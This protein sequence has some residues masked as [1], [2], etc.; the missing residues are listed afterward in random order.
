MGRI[1]GIED[2]ENEQN[3]LLSTEGYPTP[4][5]KSMISRG[6]IPNDPQ[7]LQQSYADAFSEDTEGYE[8]TPTMRFRQRVNEPEQFDP[9]EMPKN[10]PVSPAAGNAKRF[11]NVSEQND[12]YAP[13]YAAL[14]SKLVGGSNVPQSESQLQ[15]NDILNVYLARLLEKRERSKE[16]EG[17]QDQ[18]TDDSRLAALA[19]GLSESASKIGN[20]MGKPTGS[21]MTGFGKQ[22][23]GIEQSRVDSMRQIANLENPEAEAAQL[24]TINTALE[25]MRAS[26]SRTAQAQQD[27]DLALRKQQFDEKHKSAELAAQQAKYAEEKRVKEAQKRIPGYTASKDVVADAKEVRDARDAVAER[28]SFNS[29]AD[30]YM[31]AM[32]KVQGFEI[33]GSDAGNIDALAFQLKSSAGELARLGVLQPTDLKRLDELL[34]K[35]V[36]LKGGVYQAGE[37]IG[38]IFNSDKIKK[39]A[40][41]E[42]LL[43][44]MRQLKLDWNIKTEAKLRSLGYTKNSSDKQSEVAGAPGAGKIAIK[45][46]SG[47]QRVKLF[48]RSQADKLLSQKD[49][50]GQPLYIE[51]KP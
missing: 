18:A 2:Y 26:Q 38:K 23:G 49:A 36:S 32:K 31:A 40:G 22:M 30:Q 45:K 51:V 42:A 5:Q 11:S 16:L 44:P 35:S 50:N 1:I 7:A 10:L 33:G 3:N 43:A 15:A 48:S 9:K 20:I 6:L 13:V 17:M 28:E 4:L 37:Q 39:Y 21:T 47:D 24:A 29:L 14:R 41:V 12:K 34:Q 8:N 19:E 27:Y 46:L 25:Q